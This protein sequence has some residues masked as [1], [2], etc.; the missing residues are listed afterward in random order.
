MCG[1]AY[2]VNKLIDHIKTDQVMYCKKDNYPVKP[3][4]IFFGESLPKEFFDKLNAVKDCDL[5]IVIGTALAV[6][7]FN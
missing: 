7:P 6:S 4:V 5:V 3:N 2:D 1:Q